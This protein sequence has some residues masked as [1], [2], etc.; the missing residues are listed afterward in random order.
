[1]K[2]LFCL[3]ILFML[4]FTASAQFDLTGRDLL[5]MW[6]N[7]KDKDDPS[8]LVIESFDKKTGEIRGHFLS[9]SGTDGGHYKLQGW[10]N[11]R[12]MSE[13]EKTAEKHQ[14]LSVT[15]SVYWD[16]YGSI[17]S[18][19]GVCFKKDGDIQ[20]NTNWMLVRPVT[21]YEWDHILTGYD[22]FVKQL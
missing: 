4:C 3:S 16:K 5:G 14:S 21:D 18:W 17:T 8:R 15:F 22:L 7:Q 19:T 1:M 10:V 11:S 2:N 6:Y 9:P 12:V 20:L 13:E